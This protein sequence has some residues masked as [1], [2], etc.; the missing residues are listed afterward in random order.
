MDLLVKGLREGTAGGKLLMSED[1]LRTTMNAYQT[2]LRQ[3]QIEV[4]KKVAE[5]NKMPAVGGASV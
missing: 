4:V 2:E 1:E 3:K 5:M